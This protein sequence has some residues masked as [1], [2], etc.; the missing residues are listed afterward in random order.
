MGVD[1]KSTQLA[2]AEILAGKAVELLADAARICK[3]A[4]EGEAQQKL[5]RLADAVSAGIELLR[6]RRSITAA[7]ASEGGML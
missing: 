7:E 3:D 2:S 6:G 5:Y 1:T 4:G